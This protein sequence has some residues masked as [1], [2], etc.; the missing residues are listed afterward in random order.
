MTI[1]YCDLHKLRAEDLKQLMTSFPAD[2]TLIMSNLVEHSNVS[3]STFAQHAS[4][5]TSLQMKELG[6][7][8]LRELDGAGKGG[9]SDRGSDGPC[10]PKRKDPSLS[11][12]TPKKDKVRPDNGDAVTSIVDAKN[13]ANSD[14]SDEDNDDDYADAAASPEI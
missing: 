4:A 7:G 6:N 3:R 1:T 14:T 9:G 5:L 13:A 11:P 8:L 10:S 12:P 2:A